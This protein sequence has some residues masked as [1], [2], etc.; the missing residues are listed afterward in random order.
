[1]DTRPVDSVFGIPN[2]PSDA[3]LSEP[4]GAHAEARALESTQPTAG[5]HAGAHAPPGAEIEWSNAELHSIAS[6]IEE[7][8]RRLEQANSQVSTAAA[9]EATEL[10]IGR[11]F[12]EAQRFSDD[13]LS[14]LE[15]QIDEILRAAEDKAK[16]ILN[17]ATEEALEIRRRAQEAAIVSTR[18]ARELQT[19]I[20]GFTKVNTELA[21]EIGAL[22]SM[23]GPGVEQ[24]SIEYGPPPNALER[25]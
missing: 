13:S 25:D 11:L 21:K 9:V 5:S 3:L 8:Q 20:A 12:V 2:Y 6:T 23:L 18:T 7:L 1:M 17:E 10:D 14:K 15:Q 4:N 24:G 16:Q 22:N 19:A